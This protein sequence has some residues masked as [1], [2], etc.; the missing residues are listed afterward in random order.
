MSDSDSPS[1][2]A[3]GVLPLKGEGM[4]G[5]DRS[6][7]IS[8]TRLDKDQIQVRGELIDTRQD[9]EDPEKTIL[10]HNI[11]ARI[12]FKISD[13]TITAAEFGLPKMAFE[14]ICEHLPTSAEELIGLDI[15]KGLSFKMRALYGGP[16]SCF[17]L[18]S[19]LQAMLPA[20]TQARAWNNDFK[21]LDEKLPPN[22][23]PK[24]MDRMLKSVK[25]SCHAWAETTGGINKDFAVQKYDP[26]LER[27]SPRLLGRWKQDNND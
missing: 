22:L 27:I 3:P 23:V 15:F 9:Y 25:N 12:N 20:F 18:S 4:S 24:A 2:G 16:R 19:L 26:M 13:N 11:V 8:S 1:T 14:G 6:I 10:V 17:H 7:S 21:E 5:F